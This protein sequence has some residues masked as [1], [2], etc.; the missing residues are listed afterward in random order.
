MPLLIEITAAAQTALQSD[1]K[2]VRAVL[3]SAGAE[4]AAVARRARVRSLRTLGSAQSSP[5][6]SKEERGRAAARHDDAPRL[7]LPG[8]RQIVI[9]SAAEGRMCTT[10]ADPKPSS[11]F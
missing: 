3:L 4:I 6:R 10:P 2:L 7:G 8:V 11:P 5:D 9:I 1:P